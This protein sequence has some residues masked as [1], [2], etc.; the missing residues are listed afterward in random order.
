[1][2][3]EALAGE[4][5]TSGKGNFFGVFYEPASLVEQRRR[6]T[7]EELKG[8]NEKEQQEVRQKFWKEAEEK[9]KKGSRDELRKQVQDFAEWLRQRGVI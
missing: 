1:M 2:V 9:A 5:K 4:I 3:S 6:P 8:K 7:A